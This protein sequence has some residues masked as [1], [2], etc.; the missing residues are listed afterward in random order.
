MLLQRPLTAQPGSSLGSHRS[1]R[2]HGQCLRVSHPQ[3]AP[4]LHRRRQ[5]GDGGDWHNGQR[6]LSLRPVMR[7]DD[8]DGLLTVMRVSDEYDCPGH[9]LP[10]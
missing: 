7:G 8:P 10:R 9:S 2:L 3:L 1:L 4:P 5:P 6:G